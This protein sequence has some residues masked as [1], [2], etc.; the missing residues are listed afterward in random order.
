MSAVQRTNKDFSV[1]KFFRVN[2]VTLSF[3][4][5]CI[6]L[7]LNRIIDYKMVTKVWFEVTVK[8]K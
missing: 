7:T 6:L 4:T 1:Q 8:P 3:K 2:L 5:E